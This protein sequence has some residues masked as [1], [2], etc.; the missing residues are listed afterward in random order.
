[1]RIKRG[2]T[3]HKK[4]VSIMKAAKGYRG[5]RSKLYRVARESVMKA[6]QYAYVGRKNK[7]RDFRKLWI[8]RI[9]AEARVNGLSYSALM[10]GLTVSG[11]ELNRK[12]LA[13]MAVNDKASFAA[14]CETAK[15]A[16]NK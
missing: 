11:A 5:D 1:M 2:V 16:I 15:K 12:V 7:K 4:K 13:D 6:G 8:A 10:H 14:L 3:A 9:N